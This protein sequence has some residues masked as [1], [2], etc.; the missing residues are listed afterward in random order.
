[1]PK[2]AKN[3]GP[4]ERH[5]TVDLAVDRLRELILSGELPGGTQLR[6]EKL[7][8]DLGISRMPVREAL[9]QLEAEGLVRLETHKGAVVARLSTHELRECYEMRARLERWLTELA[10]PNLTSSHLQTAERALEAMRTNMDDY[11][12]G[13]L[14]WDFHAALM[15]A[16]GRPYALALLHR[17]Y[18]NVYRHFGVPIHLTDNRT[19]LITEHEHILALCRAGDVAQLGPFVERHILA[20]GEILLRRLESLRR[21]G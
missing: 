17:I 5:T 10:V 15:R 9:R 21:V 4:L 1:V 20:G 8:K 11:R 7:A 6:Q 14:N 2:S 19:P 13:R 18:R 3:S 12:W 16:A